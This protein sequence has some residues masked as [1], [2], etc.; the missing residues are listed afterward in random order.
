[1]LSMRRPSSGPASFLFVESVHHAHDRLPSEGIDLVGIQPVHE[2]QIESYA[3]ALEKGGHTDGQSMGAHVHVTP[4]HDRQH[5][6]R[7]KNEVEQ[8]VGKRGGLEVRGDFVWVWLEEGRKGLDGKQIDEH[9]KEQRHQHGGRHLP[10]CH[11]TQARERQDRL[12]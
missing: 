8:P 3:R 5:R 12:R 11:L 4:T 9:D 2:R 7:K 1:M 10:G 6:G